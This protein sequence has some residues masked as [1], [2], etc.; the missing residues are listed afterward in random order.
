MKQ[1]MILA[2]A[3]GPGKPSPLPVGRLLTEVPSVV[4]QSVSMAFRGRSAF[5]GKPPKWLVNASDVR[6]HAVTTNCTRTELVFDAPPLGEAAAEYYQQAAFEGEHWPERP[7]PNDTGF[8]LFGDVVAALSRGDEDSDR[9]DTGLLTEV[10]RLTKAIHGTFDGLVISSRRYPANGPDVLTS[11]LWDT[12]RTMLAKT[13]PARRTRLVGELDA[14]RFS[15]GAFALRLDDGHE[16]KGVVEPEQLQL[17][18]R[19][20]ASG[21]RVLVRGDAVFKPSGQLLLINAEEVCGGAGEAALWSRLPSFAQGS[22]KSQRLHR[23]QTQKTG[24]AAIIGQWPGDE[25]DDEI[26]AA[27]RELS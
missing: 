3:S 25:T 23:R 19:L 13:P 17:L 24:L 18:R 16:V 5:S 2:N 26:A 22:V 6:L 14:V 9:F 7:S 8:D 15:T 1:T 4:R 11:K 10:S 20:V 12:A 21:E 27:L